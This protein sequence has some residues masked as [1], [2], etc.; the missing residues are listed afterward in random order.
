MEACLPCFSDVQLYGCCCFVSKH[1]GADG[2]NQVR[3]V[4][5]LL[6]KEGGETALPSA[7]IN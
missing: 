7:S 2:S 3:A 6:V 1:L 5:L 4:F